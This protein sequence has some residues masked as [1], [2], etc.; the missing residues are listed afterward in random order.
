MLHSTRT[1]AKHY[2]VARVLPTRDQTQGQPQYAHA[3]LLLEVFPPAQAHALV[4]CLEIHYTPKHA[5]WL[6]IAEIELSILTRQGLTH[7]IATLEVLCRQVQSW[8]EHCNQCVGTVN[9]QFCTADARIKLK[10]LYPM[11]PSDDL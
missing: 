10:R 11:Q 2:V 5:S 6:N 8:Q 7:N 9:W 1:P 3:C 4:G